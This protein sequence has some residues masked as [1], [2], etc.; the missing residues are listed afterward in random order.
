MSISVGGV[1]LVDTAL[2]T[3]LRVMVLE[4]I[5]DRLLVVAPPGTMTQ[6]MLDQIRKDCINEIKRKY[7]QAGIQNGS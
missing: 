1:N 7:P 3:E 2:N 4:R 5:I 6:P